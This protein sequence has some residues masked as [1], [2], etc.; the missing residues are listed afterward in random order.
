MVKKLPIV[1]D[2]TLMVECWGRVRAALV[3][4]IVVT[5]V[6][7]PATARAA[8]LR[9]A[10]GSVTYGVT[11]ISAVEFAFR[12]LIN[13]ERS[14]E[15]LS[16]LAS[17]EDLVDD[18]RVQALEM[19]DAGYLY[20]Y[21]NPDLANV[22]TSENWFKLG[23]NVG[24]GPTVDILHQAFMD[25]EPHEANVLKDVYNYIGVG[26]T[27]DDNGTI[28]VAMVFMHGPEGLADASSQGPERFALPFADDDNTTHED[29]IAAITEAEITSGCDGSRELYCPEALVSR[30]QMAS[31]LTRALDLP[32]ANRD[33]FTDDDGSLHEDAINRL[34]EAGV[35]IG[36]AD[37]TFCPRDAITREQMATFLVRAL[38]LA[39]AEVDYFADDTSSPHQDSIN[40]LAAAGV[41]GG[42][43]ADS[44]CPL[45]NVTR[46]QMATFLA[47]ALGL[48]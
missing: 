41:T 11:E 44:Y 42:C 47:K 10:D 6:L 37:G 38:E 13:T 18:A 22:T 46:G 2:I 15:G 24:Y 17:F 25:S 32:S 33:Y 1:V 31:S 20:L 21:P 29:A 3:V 36:C 26:A 34:A 16:T 7:A 40:A 4:S 39:G 27:I 23:E 14:A 35:T 12:E 19:S 30:A 28:W 8:V 9:A 48:I 43:G 5:A 45:A